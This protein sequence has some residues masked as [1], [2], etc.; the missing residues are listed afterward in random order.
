VAYVLDIT[1]I[2]PVR[3][4][5]LFERFLNA[6]RISM[7]DL[8]IDFCADARE[9]VIRYVREKY[10]EKSVAQ[11]ITFGT[12]KARAAIRDVGRALGIP[13]AEVDQIAKKIPEELGIT[14]AEALKRQET[15][16]KEA[17]DQ[18][19]RV[20][21]LFDMAMRLEGLCRNM[22][23][24]AAGVVIADGELT[25]FVPLALVQNNKVVVTQFDGETL[26]DK[27][28]M[29]K[30]DF[31]GVRTL[32]VINKAL[33]L[34]KQTQGKDVNLDAIPLDDKPTFEL[35][36]RGDVEGLFQL[37]KSEGMRDLIRRLKATN[38]DDL[39]PVLALYRP[40]PLKS[41]MVDQFIE[42]RHGRAPIEYVHPSLEPLLKDTY[43]VILYQE[44]VMRTASALGGFT[45]NQADSLRKAMGK[46]IPEIMAGYRDQFVTGAVK[47]RIPQATAT[48]I[49]DLMEYFAG[50][51]FN[52][53]HSAAYAVLS[54]HTAYLKANYPTEYM[55][56][57]MSC[58]M[59]NTDKMAEYMDDCRRMGLEVLPPCVNESAAEFLVVGPMR[60]R[61]GLSAIK[62]LGSKAIES[63]LEARKKIGK[64]ESLFHFAEHV[65]LRT[66]NKAVMEGLIKSGAFDAFR[67]RRAQLMAALDRALE[68]GAQAQHDHKTG[69]MNLFGRP[70]ASADKRDARAD[71]A[72]LPDV[73]EW[74]DKQLLAFEREA[75]GFYVS[76]HPLA[77]YQ[78]VLK[79][80]ST[81]S[82]S[83]LG[84]TPDRAEVIVGGMVLR[85]DLGLTKRGDP[86]ITGE[87]E[88]MEGTTRFIMFKEQVAK[89]KDIVKPDAILFLRGGVD[90]VQS[91]SIR[92]ADVIPIENAYER[93][94][95]RVTIK[96]SAGADAG[97]SEERLTALRDLLAAH[98]GQCPVFLEMEAEN[99]RTLIRV[100]Q[101]LAVLPSQKFSAAVSNLLGEGHLAFGPSNG[102]NA[103]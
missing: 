80:F 95:G 102:S 60:I 23:V 57:L 43:G 81:T 77:R 35:L 70:A 78:S 39:V 97:L 29:L 2:D 14:L 87:I 41:G 72:S 64:F 27:V 22:S 11:I 73:P 62:G 68:M 24:H 25:D 38:F 1:N 42:R 13:L 55:A 26:S 20:K 90:T 84:E 5:L 47:N 48:Q 71:L 9:Q 34:I 61:F 88:D 93:L 15:G 49:F 67:C 44:Q 31:L 99:R 53:S 37:E 74:P 8:D 100:G 96:L 86:M 45:L 94:T 91:P 18:N 17:C 58:E 69:Q 6:E 21:E 59:G 33:A 56:A 89:F 32:T 54:Y 16:L 98:P 92:V 85:A 10:G 36:T 65:D 40:G 79:L 19:P 103:R 75:F 76:N 66:A 83:R 50:Y 101:R 82:T 30:M 4:G 28:G 3:Y 51:G 52:K 63:I 7:P 46:K 12:M